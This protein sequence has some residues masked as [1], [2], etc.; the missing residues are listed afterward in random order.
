MQGYQEAASA[1]QVR[2]ALDYD[3]TTGLLRWRTR[4]GVPKEWNTRHAG[5]VAGSRQL[6]NGR[7]YIQVRLDGVLYQAHRVIWLH[8]TGVWPL[9]EIDHEDG[10]GTHNWWTN[11]REST[12]VENS[13]NRTAQKNSRSGIKGISRHGNRWRARITAN[14]MTATETFIELEDAKEWHRKMEVML[15]GDF[16]PKSS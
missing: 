1:E 3:K 7:W 8:V 14:G 4:D 12:R 2:R 13:F 11:L 10:D 16:A 6:M 9:L 15:H 5:K